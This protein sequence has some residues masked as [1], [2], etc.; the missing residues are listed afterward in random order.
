M[1]NGVVLYLMVLYYNQ[2]LILFLL[3]NTTFSV[4]KMIDLYNLKEMIFVQPF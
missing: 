4:S 3:L 1:R 2:L